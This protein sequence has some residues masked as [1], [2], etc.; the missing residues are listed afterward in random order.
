MMD[1]KRNPQKCYRWPNQNFDN[2]EEQRK[3]QAP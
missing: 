2:V 3:F 1:A